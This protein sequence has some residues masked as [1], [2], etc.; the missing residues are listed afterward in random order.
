MGFMSDEDR[1]R[2]RRATAERER[3]RARV[4]SV[5]TTVTMAGVAAAGIVALTL[6][7]GHAQGRFL[8]DVDRLGLVVE[9]RFRQLRLRQLRLHQLRLLPAPAPPAPAHPAQARPA[10]ARRTP[11]RPARTRTLASAL[12]PLLPR[13][14]AAARP[15]P[16]GHN[17]T[18]PPGH[19]QCGRPGRASARL[20][21]AR[22]GPSGRADARLAGARRGY[23][24][25]RQLA[26]A[27]H[28]GPAGRHRPASAWTG[29]GPCSKPTWPRSTWPAAGAAPTPR[30]AGCGAGRSAGQPAAGRGHRGGAAARP[31]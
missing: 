14:L 30:S 2:I 28:P 16:A 31:N 10:P 29:P 4:R 13:V 9:L 7:G 27:R 25:C 6:P 20:A 1:D 12:V 24:G 22:R 23:R 17:V 8:I 21:D 11:A 3:G 15:P 19:A 5:T 18:R 26:R